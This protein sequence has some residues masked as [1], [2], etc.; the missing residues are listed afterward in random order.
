MRVLLI[1]PNTLTEPYPVYPLGLDYVA[2]ALAP[3]HLVRIADINAVGDWDSLSEIIRVFSPEVIGMSLRNIDN[4]DTT[5]PKVFVEEY[6]EAARIIRRNSNA[7]LVCG[8][9]GFTIFAEQIFDTVEADY[10]IIGEGERF[11]LL[12]DAI[13]NQKDTTSI[14]GVITRHSRNGIP[15]PWNKELV[16]AFNKDYS[17]V[18]F[19]VEN[20]GMLNLQTKRGCNLKCIYCSYPYI[21]GRN[22]RFIS[23][24]EVAETALELQEVGAKYFYVTDSIFNSDYPH[25][26]AVARALKKAGVT[27]PWGAF[28][29]PTRHPDDYFRIMAD[30]GLTHVEF[31]TESLSGTMLA[32]YRKPFLLDHVFNA[33]EAALDAGLHVGHYFLLGGPGETPDTLNETFS[34]AVELQKAVLFFFCGIRIYPHTELYDIAIEEGKISRSWDLLEPVFYRPD[35]I[36]IDEIVRRVQNQARDRPNWVIGSGGEQTARV[37]SRMYKRGHSGPLWEHLI[38]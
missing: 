17:H 5:N 25:S 24:K 14:P 31:G 11:A 7:L 15:D 28:F 33:H 29:A 3:D 13:T 1:S 30:A 6:R 38:R 2:G 10:G 18:R 22:L 9:S 16:R 12:L 36:D 35:S 27:I 26:I 19:Y 8:G 32:S 21:E 23:P 4:T 20:G 37:L 34:T